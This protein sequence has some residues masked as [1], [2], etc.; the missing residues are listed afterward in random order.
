MSLSLIEIQSQNIVQKGAFLEEEK[1]KNNPFRPE[2]PV[3]WE[4]VD[5][6]LLA[7]CLGTEIA[8]HFDMH[9]DTLYRKVQERYGMTYTA[10]SSEKRWKGDSLLRA[11]Q[12]EKA[13]EKDNTM[14]IWLGKQ[15]LDQREPEQV[16]HF[17]EPTES[18]KVTCKDMNDLGTKLLE[19]STDIVQPSEKKD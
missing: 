10:Y 8:A 12:F 19:K 7:G 18:M 15:R 13:L 1:K 11:K 4:K 16:V 5:E 9:S 6:L 2:K 17:S 14:M 3:D